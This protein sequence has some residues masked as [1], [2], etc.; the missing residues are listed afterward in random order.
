M[1]I[2]LIIP[3]YNE[4][5]N[6]KKLYELI[7]KELKNIKYELIFI[8]DGSTDNT[9]QK[10]IEIY[11]KDP[12]SIKGINFSR[13]FGKESAIYAGLV[14]ATGEYTCIID[15]DLQQHPKYVMEMIKHLEDNKDAD[16]VVMINNHINYPWLRKKLTKFFYYFIN[17][18]SDTRFVENASDFR[19]FRNNV[20]ESILQLS[21]TNRFS[22]GLFSWVGFNT[23]YLPYI[24]N[25]RGAGKS[26][27]T[28][29]KLIEYALDAF[30]GYSIKPIR[31]ITKAGAFISTVSFIYAIGVV[32]KKLLVPSTITGYTSMIFLILFFGG[33]QILFLGI[34]GEYISKTYLET[35]KR[36][37]YIAKNK[38]GFDEK[39]IL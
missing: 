12:D 32:I 34:I 13:N 3:C 15:G 7:I 36:P 11:E 10:I 33:L 38:I 31:V 39:N 9:Y 27:F 37:I 17:K 30:I 23:I 2:S 21:E 5:G 19:S 1:K 18:I 16:Q 29:K 28:I 24:V 20:K 25:N 35:K 22:K 14:H 26:S 8:N 4:E 6:I